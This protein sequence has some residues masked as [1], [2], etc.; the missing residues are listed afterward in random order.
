MEHSNFAIVVEEVLSVFSH[1]HNYLKLPKETLPSG[2][3][4][5]LTKMELLNIMYG[6]LFA[7]ELLLLVTANISLADGQQGK[8]LHNII[9]HCHWE[10][11]ICPSLTW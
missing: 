10:I 6:W 9:I 11:Y 4:A 1:V 2:C 7:L 3:I 5:C 8:Y